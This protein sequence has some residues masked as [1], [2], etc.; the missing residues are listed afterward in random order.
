MA[1][2]QNRVFFPQAVLDAWLAADRVELDGKELT[3]KP[4]GRKYRVVDAIRVLREVT[5][6]QDLYAIAGKVKS[7]N[8]LTELGA[9]LLGTSMLIGDCAYDVVPGFLGAPVDDLVA[10]S[11]AWGADVDGPTTEEE[12]LARFLVRE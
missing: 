4:E 8:F 5:D 10:R 9:E 2:M 11:A 3:L 6:G 1:L 7:V 12:L